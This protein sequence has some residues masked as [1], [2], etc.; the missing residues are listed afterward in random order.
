MDGIQ[1][2]QDKQINFALIYDDETEDYIGIIK[3]KDIFKKLVFKWY[4]YNTL[5]PDLS[6]RSKSGGTFLGK[7]DLIIK[8]ITEGY[9]QA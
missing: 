1:Q 6:F 3:L 9:E 5:K 4:D 7:D 2:M 8:E